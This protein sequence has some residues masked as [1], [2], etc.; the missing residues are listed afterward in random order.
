MLWLKYFFLR[1]SLVLFYN[2][3]VCCWISV[4]FDDFFLGVSAHSAAEMMVVHCLG[5]VAVASGMLGVRL[6]AFFATFL[7][8]VMWFVATFLMFQDLGSLKSLIYL[9]FWE[10]IQWFVMAVSG[11][12]L[13]AITFLLVK[14][15]GK[16][17]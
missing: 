10:K 16:M 1:L 12:G 6:P 9:D 17:E 7:S 11:F 14:V 5:L 13:F 8:G 4:A 3:T 15:S 2:L